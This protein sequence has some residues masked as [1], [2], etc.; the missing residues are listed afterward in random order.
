MFCIGGQGRDPIM[1]LQSLLGSGGE[2]NIEKYCRLQIAVKV[3]EL[4]RQ[5]KVKPEEYKMCV[6]AEDSNKRDR[7]RNRINSR[8][9]MYKQERNSC[10]KATGTNSGLRS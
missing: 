6:S 4:G 1:F 7:T 3:T 9:T 8:T 5:I 2:L 10:S